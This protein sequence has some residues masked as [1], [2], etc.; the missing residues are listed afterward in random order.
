M[1]ILVDTNIIVNYLEDTTVDEDD[2]TLDSRIMK[3]AF[4][5]K[6]EVCVSASAVTDIAY[7][8]TRDCR[9]A[10]KKALEH[11][12]LSNKQIIEYVNGQI[13]CLLKKVHILTVTE[14]EVRNAYSAEEKWNDTE[15]ALQYFTA[16]A[17]GNID[18]IVTRNGHDYRLSQIPV[19]SPVKFFSVYNAGNIAE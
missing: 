13:K 14:K 8:I 7:I 4:D 19:Y 2:M 6:I 5:G 9:E 16:M 10:N 18:C 11:E 17:D 12:R 15:D 3:L 1:R